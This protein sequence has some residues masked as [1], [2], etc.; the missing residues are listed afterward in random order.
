M[1][2]DAFCPS[3]F[4]FPFPAATSHSLLQRR[5]PIRGV[6][7]QGTSSPAICSRLGLHRSLRAVHGA[8]LFLASSDHCA[9]QL[10]PTLLLLHT[11]TNLHQALTCSPA[12][13]CH[14]ES[15]IT[16]R[17]FRGG[18]S[19]GGGAPIVASAEG[20]LL[21][22][23]SPLAAAMGLSA[24]AAGGAPPPGGAAAMRECCLAISAAASSWGVAA[25]KGGHV[26]AKPGSASLG[27]VTS[28]SWH[29]LRAGKR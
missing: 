26:E 9:G 29:A 16:D 8:A 23:A 2:A 18:G 19:K 28:R 14:F 10:L 3:P 17:L 20:S 22:S 6:G 21:P 12:F 4:P 7:S 11:A 15:M 1:L 25:E 13:S 24:S 5:L 27:G